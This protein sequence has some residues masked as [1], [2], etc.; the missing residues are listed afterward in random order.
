MICYTTFSITDLLLRGA[1]NVGH[2]RPGD[3]VRI[4]AKFFYVAEGHNLSKLNI[5]SLFN[6]LVNVNRTKSKP[7]DKARLLMR[8]F[9]STRKSPTFHIS[10]E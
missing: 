7:F 10:I 6:I 3:T 9:N 8:S 1:G 4:K 5:L 2:V